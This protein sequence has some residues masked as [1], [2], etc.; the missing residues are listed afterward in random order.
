MTGA[1]ARANVRRVGHKPMTGLIYRIVAVAFVASVAHASEHPAVGPP[2]AWVLP[3]PLPPA[4]PGTE[5]V[6]IV[7]LLLDQQS[8]LTDTGDSAYA[9]SAIRIGASQ[10]LPAAALNLAWDPALETLTLHRFAVV[11]DGKTIDLLGDGSKLTIV[12]RETNLER[13]TLDGQLTATLQP[14]D[15]R[16][17]DIVDLAFTRTRLDPALRGRSQAILGVAPSTPYG[18]VRVRV[19]WPAAKK[20]AWRAAPG[21]LEPREGRS[22]GDREL[23]Y[24]RSEVTPA[25]A[26]RGAPQRF[27]VA[28]LVMASDMGSWREVSRLMAPL[29]AT[30]AAIPASGP[31]RDE[32][33]RIAA[34][35]PDPNIRALAALK[36]VQEQVRYLLLAMDGGGYTPAPAAL[37]WTRR[38]GDCKGKTVLL[39]AMLRE[40][41]IAADPALV[42]TGAGDGLEARLPIAG[43]F[44][45]VLVKATIAGRIYWLDGTRP[46]DRVLD[47][48]RTPEFKWALPVTLAGSDLVPLIPATLSVPDLVRTLDLDA[49]AGLDAPAK[50]TGEH[51]F[52]GDAALV[53]RLG[54]GQLAPAQRDRTMRDYWRGEYD[55]VTPVTVAMIDDP[56]TGTVRL[57]MIGTA[58]LA[59]DASSGRR[60]Y[61]LDGS[62]V[63]QTLDIA[64]EPGP[65]A[66]A[67]FAVGY[68]TWREDRQTLVLPQGGRGFILD[69]GNVDTTVGPYQIRRTVKQDGARVTMVAGTRTVAAEISFKDA[70]AVKIAMAKLYE[71]EVNVGAPAALSAVVP[72]TADEF[73][74]RASE[75]LDE[76]DLQ[77]ALA[78][79]NAAVAMAPGSSRAYGVRAVIF[80]WMRDPRAEI[81]A[82]KSVALDSKERAPWHARIIAAQLSG[83]LADAEAAATRNLQIVPD[84][85]FALEWRA[86]LRIKNGNLTGALADADALIRMKPGDSAA[87]LLRIGA[88]MMGSLDAGRAAYTAYIKANPD[89]QAAPRAY[90]V[91]LAD[92]GHNAEALAAA[93]A[94]V[95][96]S[97]GNDEI[98]Y[99]RARFRLSHGD[100]PGGMADFATLIARSPEAGYLIE[101]AQLWDP[102]DRPRWVADLDAAAK[103]KP[104]EPT[105]WKA[106][107]VMEMRSGKFDAAASAI[108]ESAKLTPTDP[109]L[110]DL[111]QDLAAR[112]NPPLPKTAAELIRRAGTRLD[113]NDYTGALVDAD[114]AVALDPRSA[115]AQAARA[116]ALA[117]LSDPR[118]EAAAVKALALDPKNAAP[119]HARAIAAEFESR[120]KDAEAALTTALALWP[121]DDFA[122]GRRAM[123]RKAR[124]DRAGALADIDARLKLTPNDSWANL[125]R[126]Q[127][128]SGGDPMALAAAHADYLKSHPAD[129]AAQRLYPAA[130]SNTGRVTEAAAAMD[131]FITVHPD[132][133]DALYQRARM[134]LR[135]G[136]RTGALADL[137][138]MLALAP[139]ADRFVER[140]Q[141]RDS[142]DRTGWQSDIAAAAKLGL[143]QA[144]VWRVRAA[145]EL[146]GNNYA[147]ASA[148]LDKSAET[149]PNDSVLRDLRRT[150]LIRQG[151]GAEALAQ[152]DAEPT[153]GAR[154]L[155]TR[156]WTRAT[157][158]VQ[159]DRALADCESALHLEPGEASYLDSRAFV[160]FRAGKFAAALADYDVVLKRSPGEASSLFGRAL[161]KIAMGSDGSADLAAARRIS[162]Q[163]DE[164]F[165]RIGVKVS[166]IVQPTDKK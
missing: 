60:W 48:I 100:K 117:W 40:L 97:P 77:G 88:L 127:I 133:E 151:R 162:P 39:V 28:N 157:L 86:K 128:V 36:L 27:L 9:E 61:S 161:T 155:N 132:D 125:L 19:L 165:A 124:G 30:A 78:D 115:P 70:P 5:G 104:A 73:I 18:R 32:V 106:R 166:P 68:P 58:K 31:L 22:G 13:A 49:T 122:L 93:D 15:V 108:D 153:P 50:A 46:G 54:F 24:D 96:A 65:N 99:G 107:A 26:P 149:A 123:L 136:D 16:V 163:I 12:R 94:L 2:A 98:L 84:D 156:C 92:A 140:A 11:R 150:L 130:L 14:D 112:R 20:V 139:S 131:A 3:A 129:L 95:A 135:A 69:G 160:Y 74:I 83:R 80:A 41:G 45:H 148:A 159:L 34:L 56:A 105:L 17:G 146:R 59:W 37:T 91:L 114:A 23:L 144:T 47:L 110:A 145:M 7:P 121:T 85:T 55:F 75:R 134:R 154:A 10:A 57:T 64:R 44:D 118:F 142:K 103:L 72:T 137:G 113:S 42:S 51:R 101:R 158:N 102:K 38:Y 147:A 152:M 90:I 62:R 4:P 111:R 71:R 141:M 25:A 6:A 63:G 21:L 82:A 81:A 33:T 143:D 66:D 138:R 43:A 1:S 67:P 89:D 29:Y 126:L 87:N 164:D 119:W 35:S 120:Q 116:V 53:M 79:A 109:Q 8:R 52:E 76:R